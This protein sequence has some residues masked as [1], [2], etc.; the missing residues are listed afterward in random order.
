MS[1]L[2]VNELRI[3]K[4]CTGGDSIFAEFKGL[5][6]FE[7]TYKGLFWFCM[8]RLP[9]FG[10]DDGQWVYDRIMQ[11]NC[12]HIVPKDKQDKFLLDK[13]YAERDGIVYKAIMALKQ[14]I[15]N[16]YNF[17]EPQSVENARTIYM[18]DNNTVLPSSMSGMESTPRQN[19]GQLHHWSVYKV[20]IRHG[21]WITIK[22]MR[23]L[24]KI[25]VMNWRIIWELPSRI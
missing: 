12:N 3:F 13:M 5:N 11:V 10:G 1:F 22:A 2:T 16:G 4:Q 17:T 20:L 6:G 8:N 18:A 15:Q 25:S 24:L 14:V 19:Q 23:K 9:K 7:Y 21:A